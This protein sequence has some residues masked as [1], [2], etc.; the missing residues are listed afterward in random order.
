MSRWGTTGTIVEQSITVLTP[1][2]RC[3]VITTSA[4][5][6]DVLQWIVDLTKKKPALT[7]YAKSVYT[8]WFSHSFNFN[9]AEY[10]H[11]KKIIESNVP[12]FVRSVDDLCF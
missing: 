2:G 6:K 10:K 8:Y 12:Y 4:E 1:A 3:P 11:A 5:E 9:T 7:T